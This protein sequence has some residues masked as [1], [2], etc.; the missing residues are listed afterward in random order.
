MT[1][2]AVNLLAIAATVAVGIVMALALV[3]MLTFSRELGEYT[4]QAMDHP[5]GERTMQ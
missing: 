2:R 3:D 5:C 1:A 4:R